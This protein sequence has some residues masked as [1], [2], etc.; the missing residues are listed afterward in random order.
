MPRTILEA[1]A[2]GV[3]V[4]ASDVGGT[5]EAVDPLAS[6]LVPPS[7]PHALAQALSWI[8]AQTEGLPSPREFVNE[9]MSLAMTSKQYGELY[10][11]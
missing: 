10:L 3:P 5:P 7:D 8:L 11:Q 1:Q 2:C 9:T 4:V 6:A